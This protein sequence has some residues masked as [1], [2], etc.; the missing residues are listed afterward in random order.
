MKK[1]LKPLKLLPS[2]CLAIGLISSARAQPSG[3]TNYFWSAAGDAMTW[4]QPANWVYQW[5]DANSITQTGS[6]AVPATNG[7]TFQINI[8][9]LPGTSSLIPITITNTD[10]VNINDSLFGPMWGQTL[11]VYGN[12]TLGWG[13]F[14]W[15]TIG[16]AVTTMNL[17][18]NSSLTAANTI[19]LGTA[20]WFAGGPNVVMNVYS[21][22]VVT[23]P[24]M[25]FGGRLNLY[26]GTVNVTS[27]FNTGTATSPVF[28]GG[29][30][31]DATRSI[32]LTAGSTLV[33]PGSYDSTV[34]D[35]ISRG[36]LWVYNVPNDASDIV[37]DDNNTNWPGQTVVTTTSTGPSMT[38]LYIA[39]PRSSLSVGGLEQA[40]V[41]ADF[42]SILG[43]NVMT[44]TNL[45]Y[46]SS[47]TGVA[48]VTASGA[49]RATGVGSATITAIIG[50][51]SNSVVVTVTTY[52]NRASLVHQYSFNDAT[53][54]STVADSIPGNSPTWDGTLNGG[55]S[56]TGS[57]LVL[58][59]VSGYVQFPPGI[60]T[61]MDAVSIETWV[62][63]GAISNWAVLFTFGDSDGTL[64]HN[65]ISCQPHTSFLTAQTGI[66]NATVEQNPWFTPVLDNYTNVHIVAVYHPEAGYCSIYTNGILAAID[67]AITITMADAMATGDPLS[68]IGHSLYSADPY[69]ALTMDEFRIYQGPLTPAEIAANNALGPN[70]LQGTNTNVILSARVAG[71]PNVLLSWPTNSALVTLMSSPRI[72][73]GAVWTMVD[74]SS[75]V[76]V[77][78]NYQ[79]TVPATGTMF[80]RLQK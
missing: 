64:G 70:Q 24:W 3:Q 12:V 8:Y 69:F 63:F 49:V 71:D 25:Q 35:W 9:N 1:A 17:Y 58:D 4:S 6:G 65:Y 11:N 34:N 15:G 20:W 22:A 31:T 72:G 52:T 33:L 7:T 79:I 77:G 13:L 16:S 19:A 80:F 39:V 66:K 75:L 48:T 30:D 23:V 21:N 36:I 46:Q 45:T 29:L 43:V 37:I 41:T 5:V 53:D 2:V 73:P 67:S 47:A 62:S 10:V 18:P 40:V 44:A 28:G 76:V 54:S 57:Q 74:T 68:Y 78:D 59:G 50:T 26:G 32:N 42:G 51:F 55:A 14:A 61:N 60:L 27:G 38:A 56:L